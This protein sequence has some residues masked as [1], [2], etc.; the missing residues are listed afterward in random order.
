M[1]RDMRIVERRPGGA[2]GEVRLPTLVGE[3]V[4][5]R[6]AHDG[7]A[8][9]GTPGLGDQ[10]LADLWPETRTWSKPPLALLKPIARSPAPCR[11]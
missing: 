5:L 10:S 4:E 1:R 8:A 6:I 7:D 9:G 3:K 11:V 2:I